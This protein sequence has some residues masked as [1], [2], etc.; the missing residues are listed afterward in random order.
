MPRGGGDGGFTAKR[1]AL[2][3]E[4][5]NV[6]SAAG[7]VRTGPKAAA[8]VTGGRGEVVAQGTQAHSSEVSGTSW[9]FAGRFLLQQQSME[10]GSGDPAALEKGMTGSASRSRRT[11]RSRGAP[12]L[13][14]FR[15]TMGSG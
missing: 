1:G 5:S 2:V 10:T 6:Q 15:S 11:P 8:D 13:E 12:P 9:H 3:F 7:G 4:I 14:C